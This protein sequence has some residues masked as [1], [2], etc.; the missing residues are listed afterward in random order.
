MN[1]SM[2]NNW[3]SNRQQRED[4]EVSIEVDFSQQ[5]KKSLI[6]AASFRT[7]L[8]SQRGHGGQGLMSTGE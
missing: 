5:G 7:I 6:L 4:E 8:D 1:S 3:S 2:F